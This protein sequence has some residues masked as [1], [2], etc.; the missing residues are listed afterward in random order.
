MGKNSGNTGGAKFA[1]WFVV[2]LGAVYALDRMKIWNF[3]MNNGASYASRGVKQID[4]Y[5]STTDSDF[6]GRPTFSDAS[7]WTLFKE[8][9]VVAS[10]TGTSS[11][12]GDAPVAF[13][14]TSARWVGFW[15]LPRIIRN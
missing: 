5:V 4:I 1:K 15:L 3:N 13:N 11:Y 12:T 9:H 10:A 7:T 6:S 2:D 8:N 14:G